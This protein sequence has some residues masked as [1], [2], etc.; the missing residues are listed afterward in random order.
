MKERILLRGKGRAVEKE[1]AL[2]MNDVKLNRDTH[3]LSSAASGT[4]VRLSQKEIPIHLLVT[5][6]SRLAH[7]RHLPGIQLQTTAAAKTAESSKS[8]LSRLFNKNKSSASS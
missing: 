7:K 8:T 2:V 5:Q 4:E 1:H 6:Q 3:M